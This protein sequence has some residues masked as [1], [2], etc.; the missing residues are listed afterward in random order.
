[1]S[2]VA[3]ASS[4]KSHSAWAIKRIGW[5]RVCIRNQPGS[6]EAMCLEARRAPAVPAAANAMTP[7]PTPAA[8]AK[9]GGFLHEA[10]VRHPDRW[11]GQ[12]RGFPTKN[13][14]REQR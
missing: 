2:P 4:V 11:R 12:G 1:M 14:H 13:T 5:P 10:L 8:G 9:A 7:P 3:P 6:V